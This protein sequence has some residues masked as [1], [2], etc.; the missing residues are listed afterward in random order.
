MSAYR[1][2]SIG[3]NNYLSAEESPFTAS[4]FPDVFFE[5]LE[6]DNALSE[7]TIRSADLP[8]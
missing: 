6:E 5:S 4:V 3:S 2:T 1:S 7:L 8:L